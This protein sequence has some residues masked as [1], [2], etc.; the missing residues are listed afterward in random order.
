M[1]LKHIEGIDLSMD[2]SR[3]RA[4]SEYVAEASGREL[5][6]G[7]A[8][9]GS[10]IFA[11]ESGIHV[12]GVLKDPRVYE[13]FSPE[14]VGSER[15]IMVGKHSG[16]QSIKYKF[17]VEF[18]IELSEDIVQEILARARA[19][20]ISNKRALF[21]KELMLIYQTILDEKGTLGIAT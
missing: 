13:A 15:Q 6:L 10:N 20:A 14:E 16:S 4:L 9:T 19:L 17:A 7:K 5:P 12:D 21:D 11:H 2:T 8:I 18:G 1:A 3:L